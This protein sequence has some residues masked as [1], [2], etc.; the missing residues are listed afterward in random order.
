MGTLEKRLEEWSAKEEIKERRKLAEEILELALSSS[1]TKKYSNTIW[2]Q[3]LELTSRPDFL[4]SLKTDDSRKRWAEST[5]QII[6]KSQYKLE[7]MFRFRAHNIGERILFREFGSVS[8]NR[9]NYSHV[10]DRIRAFASVFLKAV[11]GTPKVALFLNNSLDGACCDLACL[12]YD[13]LVTPLNIHFD[14]GDLKWI[15]ERLQI[16]IVVSDNEDRIRK[17]I[18]IKNDSNASFKIIS[19]SKNQFTIRDE[20]LHLDELTAT[21]HQDTIN[22]CLSNR[23]E[24]DLDDICTVMFTSGSTGR[25][26][27]VAFTHYNLITKRFAR[28]AALPSVGKDEVLFCFLPLFH[29]FGRFFEMMG[30]IFWHGTYVFAGNPSADTLFAGLEKIQPTGLISIPLRWAQIREK[31]SDRLLEA[32]SEESETIFR[33]IVG[34]NLYWGLSAAG[35][36]DPKAFKYFHQNGV[37]LS[38]G[39]GMTEAT[40]GITM[41]PPDDYVVNSVGKSLPGMELSFTENNEMLIGGVYTARYLDPDGSDLQTLPATILDGKAYLPTGDLFKPL[42]NGHYTIVDRIKDIYKNNRGQTVAPRHVEQKF[43]SVPGIKRTFLVGDHR[44]YNVLLI[45]PDL[46]D[47]VLTGLQDEENKREYFHK[48]VSSANHDLAPYERVVNF[49]VLKRDFSVEKDELT[50]KQ[51]Y[52]RKNIEKNF[53]ET[54]HSL[55]EHSYVELK[56]EDLIIRIPRWFYRDLGLLEDAI[57]LQENGLFDRKRNLTLDLFQN[58]KNG[59]IRIG[60]LEYKVEGNIIDL[61][62]FIRQ[63]FLWFG[64]PSLIAYSP[65]KTGWDV[66]LKNIS[67]YAML[68]EENTP[69]S[70]FSPVDPAGISDSQ[71][72]TANRQISSVLFAP[73]DEAKRT[74]EK[75]SQELEY[76]AQDRL[77]LSMRRRLTALSRHSSESI[78]CQAYRV[79]L[80]VEPMPDYSVAFPAF[81]QSGLSFLNEESIREIARSSFE[82]RR[83]EALRRRLFTYRQQLIWPASEKVITQFKGVLRLL[84]NFVYF[85]REYYKPARAELASWILHRDEPRLAV[86]AQEL[87]NEMVQWYESKLTEKTNSVP[88]ETLEEKIVFDFGMQKENR[89]KITQLLLNT[90]FLK[91]SVNLAFLD[92]SFDLDQIAHDGIWISRIQTREHHQ[93]FRVSINTTSGKHY[94][95]LVTVRNDMDAEAVMETN[96]WMMVIAGYPFGQAVLPQFGCTRPELASMSLEYVNEL[97]VWDR[98]RQFAN[99]HQPTSAVPDK[100]DWYNLFNRSI[101]TFFRAWHNSGRH[102]VPGY[103]DPAN[104]VVPDF[105]FQDGALIL[106]LSG[107]VPYINTFSLFKPL[108]LSF[109]RKTTALYPQNANILEYRW[110]FEACCEGLGAEEGLKLLEEFRREIGVLGSEEFDE[111]FIQEL[112]SYIN[113]SSDSYFVPLPLNNAIRRYNEWESLNPNTTADAK[114]DQI[115]NLVSLYSIY[116]LKKTARYYLYRH[117]FF[118]TAIDEICVIFDELLHKINLHPDKPATKHVELSDL[119]A[120]LV[121]EDNRH[122]FSRMVFPKVHSSNALS[123]YTFGER[124]HRHVIVQTQI[125]DNH[126]VSLSVRE[127]VDAEEVGQLYRLFYQEHFPKRVSVQDKYLIVIDDNDHVIGGLCYQREEI[128]V[129]HL[130]GIVVTSPM[131]RRGIASLLLEDFIVRM[132]SDGITAV[133]TGFMMR[134]FCSKRGFKVDPQWGGLVRF[135]SDNLK[136]DS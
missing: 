21:L 49:T 5:F 123:I 109:Y 4:S 26:K 51:S 3:Y 60:N 74:L 11:D 95:L 52:K 133:K 126:K 56:S 9:W 55:Y 94:D 79:L 119:Q 128:D 91:Q 1:N 84:V 7:D 112:D 34:K 130:D 59:L 87:F 12:T 46:D 118:S 40:G 66:P 33:S 31:A 107:W 116:K 37:K 113:N 44:S 86:Y 17:L 18:A 105:D 125:I 110:M 39:F 134:E 88:L 77:A 57:E 19:T 132:A 92:S 100:L 106:S 58:S 38:S 108:Y 61:G 82:K 72:I 32:P 54:I 64:N 41:S 90:T 81:V 93:L 45:V 48:I 78:R 89:E 14:E 120:A 73:I 75:I 129:V 104:V 83:L 131:T 101:S 42:G 135:L 29:T 28:A 99:V 80:L 15:L 69:V 68:P 47:P 67:P 122:A 16:N 96:L 43:D 117:T 102:I 13:I 50:A 24:F 121:T 98:I 25:P 30:M 62:H 23:P 22:T 6:K 111:I 36:L 103:L 27:G 127:P 124:D 115:E 53:E 76:S 114:I 2:H 65:C 20:V 35:Y 70:G 71:L 63:P 136:N 85:N 97:T 8:G 10:Y